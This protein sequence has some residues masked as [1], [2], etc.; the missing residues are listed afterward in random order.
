[1]TSTISVS[2][3]LKSFASLLFTVFADTVGDMLVDLLCASA[4]IE[5]VRR[6]LELMT[7]VQH[8]RNLVAFRCVELISLSFTLQTLRAFD[9]LGLPPASPLPSSSLAASVTILTTAG[10]RISCFS[11]V[12]SSFMR[13]ISDRI[14]SCASCD[15]G[16]SIFF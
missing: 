9:V 2:D 10:L 13:L 8:C 4:S 1:M 7:V 6:D 12:F 16:M 5:P 15:C 14:V 3:L 11:K